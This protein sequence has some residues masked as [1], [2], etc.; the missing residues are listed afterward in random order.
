MSPNH[1]ITLNVSLPAYYHIERA[2]HYA[3]THSLNSS[4]VY[5]RGYTGPTGVCI[6]DSY[7]TTIDEIDRF[8]S[9]K[10]QLRAQAAPE[11]GKD[12]RP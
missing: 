6:E 1:T 3:I 2:I 11:L 10:D 4:A 7:R 12:D 8:R 5:V 9:L